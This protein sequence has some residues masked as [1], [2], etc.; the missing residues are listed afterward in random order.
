MGEALVVGAPQHEPLGSDFVG[1]LELC[2]QVRGTYL[3]RH[4]RRP[5]LDPRVLLHLAAEE[6][7][8]IRTLLVQDLRPLDPRGIFDHQ[9]PTLA[10][11]HV[12]CLMEAHAA[13]VADSAEGTAAE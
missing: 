13:E 2:P 9:S 6:L 8:A 12:L 11:V 5:K 4:E 1:C 3:A 7:A 10:A